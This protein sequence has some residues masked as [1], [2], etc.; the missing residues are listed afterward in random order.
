MSQHSD[1]KLHPFAFFSQHLSQPN[2]NYDEGDRELLAIKLALEEWR[3][4][5]EGSEQPII[6]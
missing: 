1:Q 2:R 6:I 5:L 3:L 4:W